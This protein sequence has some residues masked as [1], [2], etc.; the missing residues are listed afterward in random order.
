MEL[1]EETSAKFARGCV[2]SASEVVNLEL[3]WTG[4]ARSSGNI[5][6]NAFLIDNV[7]AFP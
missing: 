5:V 6:M 4:I 2:L 7:S 3:I 1:S